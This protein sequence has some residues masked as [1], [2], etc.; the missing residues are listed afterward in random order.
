MFLCRIRVEYM[1]QNYLLFVIRKFQ[2]MYTCGTINS[3][4]FDIY[5]IVMFFLFLPKS[6]HNKHFPH[7]IIPFP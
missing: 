6:L 4:V 5:S 7:S 3:I 2:Y 1:H